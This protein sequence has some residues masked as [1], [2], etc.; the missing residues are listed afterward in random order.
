[1]KLTNEI[2][3]F[4]ASVRLAIFTLCSLALTSII[5]TVI[6]QNKPDS[7]YVETYG[8]ATA[9]FFQVLDIPDMYGSW[10]FLIL[11]GLLCANLIICSIDRFPTTWRLMTINQL[12]VHPDR[13]QGMDL[14]Q[15][16]S[17]PSPVGESAGQLSAA[18]AKAGWK[19]ASREIETGTLLF[20]G[21]GGWSRIG[22]YVVHISILVI[23]VG[24]IIGNILGFK[25]TVM[26]PEG[27]S[28]TRIFAFNSS[29]PIDLGFEILCDSFTVD[30]Y[31]NGMPKEYASVLTVRENGKEILKQT[32]EVN[33]PLTYRGITFYQSS[34]QAYK[35]FI[36]SI[37]IAPEKI[38]KVFTIPYQQEME[39]P[40]QNIRFG[41]V[42]AEGM[43]DRVTRIKIWMKHGE[44][45]ASTFWVEN[46]K[47][48][49]IPSADKTIA[50][51][52]KQ[53]F[54]TGLQVAKDP[55]VWLVYLGCC[56]ML[57]GLYVSFFVSHQRL[58]LLL[59]PDK[60]GT[61]TSILLAGASNK[62]QT[63]FARSFTRL[64]DRLRG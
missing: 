27:E 10:W 4:F 20:A 35:D 2:W 46:G 37:V 49:A 42:N 9:Q 40:E 16:W 29:E 5:G 3:G 15:E 41:V 12:A 13:L 61:G 23:F 8:P 57:I 19:P 30:Y 55:G 22:V 7:W 56:L 11:L 25:G 6:P 38:G 52:A 36:V 60:G 14:R 44:Q 17:L 21:K 47:D 28:T 24:A 62:N 63:G 64:A 48:A 26:L 59:R 1:M 45:P 43:G 39:W 58:W 34:Y 18:L 33:Q 32:I 31:P 53:M 54:A 51:S 50:V